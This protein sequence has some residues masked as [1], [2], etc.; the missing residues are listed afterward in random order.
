MNNFFVLEFVFLATEPNAENNLSFIV[1]DLN[2]S[3]FLS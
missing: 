3:I 2:I 1:M